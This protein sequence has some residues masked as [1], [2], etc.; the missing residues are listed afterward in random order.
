MKK[1]IKHL[2]ESSECKHSKENQAPELRAIKK[3]L[4]NFIITEITTYRK[5]LGLNSQQV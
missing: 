3:Q 4:F 1:V 5:I 2:F